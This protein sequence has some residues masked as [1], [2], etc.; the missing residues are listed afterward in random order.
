MPLTRYYIL[1]NDTT[2]AGG[3]VQTTTNPTIFN[4]SG[5]KQSCIGDDV[6]CPACQSMGK[7]VPTGPRLSFSLGGAMP[8]LNDDL[9]LCKCNPPPK[10][11]HSQTSFKEIIDDNRLAQYQKAREQYRQSKLQNNFANT[12]ANDDELPKFTV[13]F[14][15]DDNY[16]GRYG[17]DWLR[18]EYVYN[19]K[20]ADGSVQGNIAGV[21]PH[22]ANLIQSIMSEYI[23]HQNNPV[24]FIDDFISNQTD[25]APAWLSIFAKGQ[26]DDVY[27]PNV[28]LHLQIEQDITHGSTPLTD[29]G[30]IILFE[31]SQGLEVQ[32]TLTLADYLK[33]AKRQE[34]ELMASSLAMPSKA[35]YRYTNTAFSINITCTQPIDELGYV[36]I[37]AQKPNGKKKQVG[38]LC[39]YPNSDIPTAVIQPVLWVTDRGMA[40]IN[41]PQ[42]MLDTGKIRIPYGKIQTALFNQAL[43]KAHINEYLAI[44]LLD[45]KVYIGEK[46]ATLDIPHSLDKEISNYLYQ[47]N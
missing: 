18:D 36:K 2:T 9:C 26:M 15:R 11:V 30:T 43:I 17:F 6:W 5:K 31:Y 32:S 45:K 25:Y 14:R 38:L 46:G 23:T 37:F 40:I 4:I 35:I 29:D 10:L 19:I 44:N 34:I 1:E 8:A 7:I 41:H 13:H 27:L 21:S 33:N 12:Q 47:P 28:N 42:G 3:I 16:Q 24:S 22:R 20:L 39:V